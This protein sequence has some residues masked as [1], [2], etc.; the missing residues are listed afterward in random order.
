MDLR[1]AQSLTET[2]ARYLEVEDEVKLR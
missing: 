2:K 1:S